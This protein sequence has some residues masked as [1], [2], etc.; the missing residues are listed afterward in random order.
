MKPGEQHDGAGDSRQRRH[1][2]HQCQ[3]GHDADNANHPHMRVRVAQWRM[4]LCHVS[5]SLEVQRQADSDYLS[6]DDGTDDS[7]THP[8]LMNTMSGNIHVF[9]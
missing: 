7:I 2:D 1:V 4:F 9:V 6:Q 5:L 8:T 3:T